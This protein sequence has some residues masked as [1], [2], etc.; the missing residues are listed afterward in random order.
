MLLKSLTHFHLVK[1]DAGLSARTYNRLMRMYPCDND[2]LKE[3]KLHFSAFRAESLRHVV[4]TGNKRGDVLKFWVGTSLR[5]YTLQDNYSEDELNCFFCDQQRTWRIPPKWEGFDPELIRKI[6]FG[7]TALSVIS[8]VW[9]CFFARPYRLMALV[10]ILWQVVSIILVSVY[11]ESFTFLESVKKQRNQRQGC[12][13]AALVAPGFA[14]T[15]REMI[16]FTY[17]GNA[18]FWRILLVA[19]V[20]WIPAALILIVR[21]RQLRE[22]VPEFVAIL[23]MI[24]FLNLGTAGYLN[25]LLDF[26]APKTHALE[27]VDKHIDRG[28]KSTS[29]YITVDLPDS[30]AMELNISA[31]K[32]RNVAVGEQILVKDSNGA[33][34]IRYFM[35]QIISD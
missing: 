8:S 24:L 32:Y 17:L 33:F 21:A 10:C 16:D 2:A 11:P 34:G 30:E 28:S 19:F 27:I 6:T 22:D 20:I 23:V 13:L 31:G 9:F 7:M 15:L 3:L 29:Y 1:V 35:T 4:L 12:L 25:Y 26:S 14:L 5:E 18:G